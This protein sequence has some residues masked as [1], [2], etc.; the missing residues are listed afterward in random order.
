[1]IIAPEFLVTDATRRPHRGRLNRALQLGAVLALAGV[2]AALLIACGGE[3][4]PDAQRSPVISNVSWSP[5]G[6]R[7]AF[8]QGRASYVI[9]AD[10]TGRRRLLPGISGIPTF[11]P[12][13]H[14][15]AV[16][17][18]R[19]NGGARLYIISAD[20]SRH[21]LAPDA[22]FASAPVWSPDGQRIAFVTGRRHARFGDTALVDL[23]GTNERLLTRGA[24]VRS[25]AWSPDGRSVAFIRQE[26]GLAVYIADIEGAG[27]RRVTPTGDIT[28]VPVWSPDGARLLVVAHPGPSVAALIIGA[29]YVQWAIY[30]ARPTGAHLRFLTSANYANV[31]PAWSPRGD[32][33]AYERHDN[34]ERSEIYTIETGGFDLGL[35]EERLTSDGLNGSPAW[36][37]DGRKIA[38]AHGDEIHVMDA[39]GDHRTRLMPNTP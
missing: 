39:D 7:I 27:M 23:D 37:P 31:S 21:V 22:T 38:F 36:S 16:I 26:R 17:G 13:S 25:I 24:R 14:R 28:A 30:V 35:S 20:G 1:M 11:S 12:D 18:A 3:K 4:G 10:G 6:K 9:N 34:N 29:P 15:I 2:G 5:D 19:T 8:V 33:V 32:G